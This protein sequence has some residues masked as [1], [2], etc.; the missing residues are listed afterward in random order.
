MKLLN[1]EICGFYS[2]GVFYPF[3][4]GGDGK[5]GGEPDKGDKGGKGG[6]GD[7]STFN[8]EQVNKI[9]ATHKKSLQAQAQA[10]ESALKKITGEMDTL[11]ETLAKLN[12]A[13]PNVDLDA[14]KNLSATE[15]AEKRIKYEQEKNHKLLEAANARNEET[16]SQLQ[17]TE[18]RRLDAERDRFLDEALHKVGCRDL[19][20][21][22]R[23]FREQM[24]Y[25]VEASE[26]SFNSEKG[27]SMS[28]EDGVDADLPDFMRDTKARPGSGGKS[29]K[30][31]LEG[32][33]VAKEDELTAA[34]DKAR[35]TGDD[36]EMASILRI[37]RE[38]SALKSQLK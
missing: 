27:G 3:I 38:L 29:P 7:P 9:L 18:K 23:M 20:M 30:A 8:Q 24:E 35:A 25:D 19:K 32:S 33:I 17:A 13:D 15:L 16:L 26:W 12:V 28:V 14:D 36:S 34:T 11:K 5:E 37:K 10:S 2:D 1:Q 21:A 31:R 4:A 6:E 22:K